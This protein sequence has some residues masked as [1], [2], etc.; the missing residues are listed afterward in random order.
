MNIKTI[1]PDVTLCSH[2]TEQF[3]TASV[4]INIITPLDSD[5]TKKALLINLLSRTNAHY[6]TLTQMNRRLGFLYDATVSPGTSKIGEAHVLSLSMSCLDNRFALHG[7][8]IIE[9]ALELLLS[10]LFEADITEE[11]LEREK[12]LLKEKIDSENDDKRLYAL[13]RLFEEM[14]GSEKYSISP[15]GDKALIDSVTADELTELWKRLLRECAFQISVVGSFDGEATEKLLTERFSALE[16][17]RVKPVSTEFI[18]RAEASKTLTETQKVQQ[19]KLVIGLRAGTTS[20]DDNYAATMMMTSIFGGGT[21]S[22]LFTNVREKMS[23]CYYCSAGLIQ[24]KGIITVQSGVE[25]DNAQKALDAI[26]GELDDMRKGNFTEEDIAAAKM[27]F[28]NSMHSAT[29]GVGRIRNFFLSQCT[30]EKFIT[31]EEYIEMAEKVTREDIIAAAKNVSLDTV[32]ILKG[33]KED[34]E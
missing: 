26:L 27:S 12:R 28:A 3:K 10:C 14:C 9:E 33:E 11:N 15:L 22:K 2:R 18:P 25:T 29:D 32:Y 17:D 5:A 20:A 31:P 1:C 16:R 4:S 30:A 19:G 8:S 23:L 7:D 6:P 24:S 21:F 34:R 13:Q